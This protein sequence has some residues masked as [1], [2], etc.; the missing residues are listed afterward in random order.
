MVRAAVGQD[1]TI[2]AHSP[3]N[4]LATDGKGI[5]HAFAAFGNAIFGSYA[6]TTTCCEG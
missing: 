3:K 2:A 1:G 6:A 5:D 4:W